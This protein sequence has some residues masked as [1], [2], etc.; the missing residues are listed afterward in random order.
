MKRKIGLLGKIKNALLGN[1]IITQTEAMAREGVRDESQLSNKYNDVQLSGLRYL[2]G[3][4]CRT[5]GELKAA[6]SKD[7]DMGGWSG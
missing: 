6:E 1:P 7:P 5:V 2:N 4:A 3:V